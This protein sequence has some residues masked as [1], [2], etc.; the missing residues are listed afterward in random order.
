MLGVFGLSVKWGKEIIALILRG[1]YEDWVRQG[2]EKALYS[3]YGTTLEHLTNISVT[4]EYGHGV[5]VTGP[6]FVH[7][8]QRGLGGGKSSQDD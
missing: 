4:K 5:G 3:V 2:I 8:C 6:V 1:C 7:Q